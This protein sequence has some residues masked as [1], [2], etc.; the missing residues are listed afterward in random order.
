MTGPLTGTRLIPIPSTVTTWKRWRRKH[1]ET[2]VLSTKTGYSRDYTVD[3]YKNYHK[4]RFSFFG[5]GKKSPLLR[6]KELI[7]GVEFGGVKR[8]YPFEVLKS[9]ETPLRDVIA[10][11]PVTVYFDKN[12]QE[13]FATDGEG[14]RLPGFV[15]YWFVWYSF[16]PETEVYG[17][18]AGAR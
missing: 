8:A 3:P 9:I 4:S 14:K 12:S 2:L 6:D 17:P 5:L 18:A 1:P 16:H 15:S 10:E 11:R 13:A 7:L